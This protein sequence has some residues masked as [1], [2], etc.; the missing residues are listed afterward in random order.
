[1]LLE[2][3]RAAG[4]TLRSG[5]PIAYVATLGP[6]NRVSWSE[7]DQLLESKEGA[8]PMPFGTYV[9]LSELRDALLGRYDFLALNDAVM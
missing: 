7:G 5:T 9:R 3:L 1:M 6:R 2:R 8:W 4:E